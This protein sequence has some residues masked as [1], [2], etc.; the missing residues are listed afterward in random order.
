LVAAGLWSRLSAA[1]LRAII[2]VA[3]LTAKAPLP[4][5]DGF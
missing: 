1:P 5:S 2:S 3:T 4:A